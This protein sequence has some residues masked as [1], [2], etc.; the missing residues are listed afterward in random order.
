MPRPDREGRLADAAFRLLAKKAWRELT[1]ASIAKAAKLAW[2]EVLAIAPSKT[3]VAGVM[4][5]RLRAEVAHRY[6]ADRNSATAR[7]RVFDVAMMWFDVQ[8]PRK[9]ALR[10]LYDELKS[11]PLTLISIRRDIVGA[12]EAMLALADADMGRSPSFRAA[13]VAGVLAHAIPV[14]LGDDDDMGKTMAQLDRDLRRVERFLWPAPPK[15]QRKTSR[16]R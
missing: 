3:A 5:R 10:S 15:P 16:R 9:I 7:E 2:P 4:L 11:D 12:V 6:K 14:W 8:Q 1:L 13:I